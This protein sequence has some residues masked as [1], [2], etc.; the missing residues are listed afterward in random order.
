MS[1]ALKGYEHSTYEDCWAIVKIFLYTLE[2]L[3]I[4][5]V[6]ISDKWFIVICYIGF[7]MYTCKILSQF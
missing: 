7:V 6:C 1:D 3:R 5:F 2:E 4:D